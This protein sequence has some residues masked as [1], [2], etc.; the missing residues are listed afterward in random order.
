MKKSYYLLLFLFLT[1][2]DGSETIQKHPTLVNRY[3]PS[4]PNTVDCIKPT[5]GGIDEPFIVEGNFGGNLADMRVYFDDKKAVL[6]STDGKTILGVVPKQ[7]AGKHTI[8]VVCDGDSITTDLV[9][10]YQQTKSVKTIAGL[11][12][13]G[14]DYVDGDLNTARFKEP[15]NVATVKGMNGDNIIV[16][17]SWWNNRVRLISLDDTK[18]VTLDQTKSFG[19]PAVD[20]TREKFYLLS[21]W[22]EDRT[23]YSYSR[24][25]NWAPKSTDIIIPVSD[26]PGQIWSGRFMDGDDNHLYLL[27]SRLNFCCVDL[28]NL[29]YEVLPVE[30]DYPTVSLGDRNSLAYSKYHKCFFICVP[31]AAGIYKLYNDN[32]VW[33]REKYAGFNGAGSATG[34]RLNDAQFIAP[35]AIAPTS[36]GILY[37]LCRDGNFMSKIEGDMVELVAGMP[38]QGGQV[39]SSTDPL[40]ARFDSPQDIATDFEDN[41]YIAGGWDR[42][43]R[44]LSIE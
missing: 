38:G 6:V 32:G 12:G 36:D 20:N 30:G 35:Y 2:C 10:K 27:D 11:F 24:S 26:M 33:R 42:T 25:E 7:K 28:K 37:V 9:F 8:S 3:D 13:A 5:Y 21:H 22:A 34:H 1:A 43:V 39:N 44:K 16:V 41:I 4:M 40:E 29:T 31:E 19:T 17:E 14:D 15:S 23:I 18:V